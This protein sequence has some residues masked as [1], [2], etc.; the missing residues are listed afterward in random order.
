MK[1]GILKIRNFIFENIIL[2]SLLSRFAVILNFIYLVFYANKNNFI[3]NISKKKFFFS[4]AILTLLFVQNLF[5]NIDFL[6]NLKFIISIVILII[7]V[8]LLINFYLQNKYLYINSLKY[9]SLLSL[10]LIFDIFFFKIFNFSL[11][12]DYHN[13]RTI[14]A[15]YSGLLLDEEIL[16]FFL[17]MCMPLVHI[18]L[19]NYT[20]IFKKNNFLITIVMMI[21]VTAIFFTGERRSFLASFLL[22]FFF[23]PYNSLINKKNFIFITVVFFLIIYFAFY[24]ISTDKFI[25]KNNENKIIERMITNT[26]Y[27]V[28][29][30]PIAL[31][32]SQEEYYDFIKKKKIGDWIILYSNAISLSS[33]NLKTIFLGSGYKTFKNKCSKKFII[34]SNHPHNMY[35]EIY[36]SFGLLVFFLWCALIFFFIFYFHKKKNIEMLGYIVS[37]FFPILP[38]GSILSFNLQFYFSIFLGFLLV[39]F[40]LKTK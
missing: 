11:L 14:T 19:K 20:K 27:I 7:F 2:L 8:L 16:G 35:I 29:S 9:L 32:K 28:E 22:M 30:I 39:N 10:L 31:N 3:L 40:F 18:Y 4:F 1:S 38:S 34:C 13:N 25:I 33:E 6:T 26:I 17:F 12:N 21:F 24:K 37:F 5:N 15:R 23:L 36:Y